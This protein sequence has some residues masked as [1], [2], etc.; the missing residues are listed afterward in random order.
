MAVPTFYQQQDINTALGRMREVGVE[1]NRQNV[2]AK[3]NGDVFFTLRL[4]ELN[5]LLDAIEER[6]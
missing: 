3:K 2:D 1:V 5:D 4:D 6:A